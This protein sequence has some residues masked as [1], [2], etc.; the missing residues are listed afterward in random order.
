M[1]FVCIQV[2]IFYRP[3]CYFYSM[4][5]YKNP[6]QVI[7]SQEVYDNKWI[8]VTEYDVINPNGGKGI[9]GKVHLKNIAIGIIVLDE[10]MNTW[11]VGQYRFPLNTYSWEIPE[12]GGPLEIDPLESA[13]RELIEETGL[14]AHEWTLLLK[15]HTSNSISDE[16]ALI[17]LARKLEQHAA[18]PEETEQLAIKKL[19]FEEVWE[20]TEDGLI[21]DA[22]S[23]VAIQKV[24]LMQLMGDPKLK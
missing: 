5:E 12:G 17:Y 18:M 20:M 16:Y 14:V 22:M 24:R 11:L 7:S 15:L 19:P 21:T 10:E 6:W 9:Y 2:R 13:K 4:E 1:P 23:V 8:N 3:V